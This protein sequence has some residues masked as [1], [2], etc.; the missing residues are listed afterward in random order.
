MENKTEPTNEHSPSVFNT[1]YLYLGDPIAKLIISRWKLSPNQAGVIFTIFAFSFTSILA[2]INGRFLPGV[3][4]RS[5]LTDWAYLITELISNPFIWGYYVWSCLAPMAVIEKLADIKVISLKQKKI[6]AVNKVLSE[7]YWPWISLLLAGLVGY[8]YLVGSIDWLSNPVTFFLRVAVV[9]F[10]GAYAIWM[11]VFRIM[12]ATRIFRRVMTEMTLHPLH[13]DR[14]GGLQPLGD[15]AFK[16]SW[17]IIIAGI[18]G[19]LLEVSEILG[20][21]QGEEPWAHGIFLLYLLIAPIVFFYPLSIAHWAMKKAKS[22]FLLTISKEFN[23]NID[24]VHY[25]INLIAKDPSKNYDLSDKITRIE[26]LQ[27]L[28]KIGETFPVWPFDFANIRRFTVSM[29]WPIITFLAPFFVKFVLIPFLEPI[30]PLRIFVP[31][32]EILENI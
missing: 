14:V 23:Q 21:V 15:F 26:Q 27:K 16:I 13:P 18:M 7:K 1:D 24:H 20:G 29:L 9:V 17:G 4:H 30:I 2:S 12:A 8:L 5:L 32:K 25:G 3:G 22:N 19:A 10:P 28:H 31:L 6:S 11:V